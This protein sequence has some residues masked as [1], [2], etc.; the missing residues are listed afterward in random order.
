MLD[1]MDGE[2][3]Q[4][5][6]H[7][8][9]QHEEHHRFQHQQKGDDHLAACRTVQRK[10]FLGEHDHNTQGDNRQRPAGND[11]VVQQPA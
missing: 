3:V 5:G 2:E 4:R 7:L 10:G 6:R 8:G 1:V 11:L 9:I